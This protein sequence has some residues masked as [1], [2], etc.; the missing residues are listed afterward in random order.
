MGRNAE[1]DLHGMLAGRSGLSGVQHV[2]TGR[3]SRSMLR[4]DLGELLSET[5]LGPLRLLRAKYKPGRYLTASFSATISSLNNGK[6]NTR[7]VDIAWRVEGPESCKHPAQ[8]YQEMQADAA[9]RGLAAPFRR[10]IADLPSCEA[11]AQV[12]PLDARFPQLV[13]LADPDYVLEMLSGAPEVH[14][15]RKLPAFYRITPVRYRPGQRH[16]LRYDPDGEEGQG[17]AVF[18]KLFYDPG[19]AVGIYR[20]AVRAN[21]WLTARKEKILSIRPLAILSD[22]GSILYPEVTGKSFSR[23][24]RGPAVKVR[25]YLALAG[26][27]LRAL[28]DMPVEFA[29]DLEPKTLSDEARLIRR[30]SE[31]IRVLSPELHSK[32][33]EIVELGETLYWRMP[34]EMAAF[35]HSD[36]KA[37]HLWVTPAGLTLI[38]FDSCSQ[39]DPASDAGKFLADLRWWYTLYGKPG[40]EEAQHDFMESYS[41]GLPEGRLQRSR[42]YEAL[43]LTKIAIRRV[44]LFDRHWHA[45][46]GQLLA[47]AEAVLREVE[48]G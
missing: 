38:D 21:E 8:G 26:S 20:S 9:L 32:I 44:P 1:L 10:L 4:R 29:E 11:C 41:P 23:Y 48:R 40:V 14:C 27:I 13:R 19:R 16:V 37:D 24:L 36:Y 7:P 22:E 18:A 42:I 43:I 30:A 6:L 25:E 34:Q 12:Y 17:R 33:Q 31:H 47:L 2:L 15:G 3:S 5:V 28:N 46:T 39:S 35:T 45:R